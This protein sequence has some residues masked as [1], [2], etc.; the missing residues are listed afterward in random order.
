MS[1]ELFRH[2]NQDTRIL[3]DCPIY[4][5]TFCEKSLPVPF[6]LFLLEEQEQEPNVL[7]FPQIKGPVENITNNLDRQGQGQGQYIGQV[8][9]KKCVYV[10]IK[11]KDAEFKPSN[12]SWFCLLDEILN[13]GSVINSLKVSPLCAEFLFSNPAYYRRGEMPYVAFLCFDNLKQTEITHYFGPVRENYD[14]YTFTVCDK[15]HFVRYAIFGTEPIT[16][17]GVTTWRIK[18]LTNAVALSW[19]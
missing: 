10:F 6:L 18:T 8:I 4:F 17:N 1:L 13:Y 19:Q 15:P 9:Y 11:I 2:V 7:S 3:L 14:Y 5:V 16:E 12:K